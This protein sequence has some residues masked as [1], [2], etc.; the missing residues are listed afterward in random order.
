[1]IYCYYYLQWLFR[2]CCSS[3]FTSISNVTSCSKTCPNRIDSVSQGSDRT[4]HTLH[5]SANHSPTLQSDHVSCSRHHPS[6]QTTMNI[7]HP[8][9]ITTRAAW[10][11][12]FDQRRERLQ[13]RLKQAEQAEWNWP[14]TRRRCDIM[15]IEDEIKHLDAEEFVVPF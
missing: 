13:T 7:T 2:S 9:Q 11:A 6:N 1:M 15:R 4:P 12:W 8:S 3:I 14:C 5:R 10:H